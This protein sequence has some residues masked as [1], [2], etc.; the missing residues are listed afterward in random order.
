MNRKLLA[1][2]VCLLLTLGLRAQEPL[3]TL[4]LEQ[5][6]AEALF[7]AIE[8]QTGCRIYCRPADVDSLRLTVHCA[9]ME[10]AEALRL[11]LRE[12]KLKVSAFEKALFVA[13]EKELLTSL[14]P[15]YYSREEMAGGEAPAGRMPAF[16]REERKASSENQVYEIGVASGQAAGGKA[17]VSGVVSDFRTG[18]PMAGIAL[19]I[20]EPLTGTTTDAF[21]FYSIQLPLGRQE[22]CIQGI[23]MKDTRRQLEV[24]SAGK[25]D[26][27]LEE[28]VYS[29]KEISVSSERT[30]RIR[31]TSIGVERLAIK[32]MKNI[33]TAFG[34]ADILKIILSLPGVKTVGEASGGFNVRGGA[35]DQNLI[36]FNDG[37]VYNPTHLFGFFS[38]FNPDV[39]KDVEL[40]KSSIP[41]RFGGRLSSV[42]DINTREGNK[43]EFTGS[44]SLGLL[45]SR[46]SLE[47]PVGGDRTSFIAGGR[48]TYSD[49]ILRQLPPNSGYRD[50]SAGFY[51]VNLGLSHHSDERNSF[52]LNGYFSRDRFGFEAG[53]RYAYRNANGSLKWRHIFGDRL[54]GV[55]TAGYDGYDFRTQSTGN[56][57]EAY[58]YSFGIGQEFA[59]ADLSWYATDKHTFDFGLSALHYA[60]KPGAYL[61]EGRQSLVAPNVMQGEQAVEMAVYAGD[62]WDISPRLSL[63]IGLRYSLYGA[64]GPR[65]YNIYEE[66]ALPSLS[67]LLGTE[68]GRGLFKTYQGPEYRL[69][70]RYALTDDWSVKAGINRMQQYIHKLSNTTVMSPT[71]SWKLSDANIRPQSGVQIAAGAY[72][73]FA[74]HTIETSVEAYYKTM[75][76]YL[77]YRKGAE[78]LMNP[79]IETDV[80][81]SRGRAYGIELMVRRT[82]GKL[83]GWASYTW[84]RTH[85]QQSDP[86]IAD[87]VNGG[88]WYPADFDKPHE[89]KLAGNYRF[90][91]RFSLSANCD[92]STGRPLS[93]PVAKYRMSG[94][95]FVYY[96]ERNQYR[97]PDFFRVDLSINI[98]PSHR[99]TKLTHSSFSLG[100]YN[101]TGRKN[102]YSVYYIAE[103]GRLQG[104]RLAIFGVPIP[105]ISYNLKF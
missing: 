26:I 62:R 86:R 87:P 50:G 4:Y 34:E 74:G 2:G 46:L 63:N 102:A 14:P 6:P 27:E 54:T 58:T 8:G 75:N 30:A 98:E 91:H 3:V 44:A 20:R 89:F 25:L 73:N 95:E 19:F 81:P 68:A 39:V 67:S 41:Y 47:G 59:K 83:N 71:D 40:Y 15:A 51:D 33:P 92:Y 35:T 60:L 11:A 79:H 18:E 64:S 103:E 9:G 99:L 16:G 36:L 5:A 105:Y 56:P 49:W 1:G 24:H 96:S 82:Q 21:G 48:T 57:A 76:N 97:I 70:A 85:L 7:A 42:L 100:V 12:T 88:E 38:A 93:L 77:D 32:D 29:L 104:Y 28:Q 65:T 22:L 72:R 17:T 31:T 43:K 10:A 101:V 45:T 37:T 13:E 78:L 94:G 69:S 55:F 66:G 23:G 84:S 52:Y 90:T 61:P 53:E 80:L